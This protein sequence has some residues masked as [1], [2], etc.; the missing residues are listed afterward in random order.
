MWIKWPT[1]PG[2]ISLASMSGL[3]WG[4]VGEEMPEWN[5]QPV[6]LKCKFHSS[7]P[8]ESQAVV[9]HSTARHPSGSSTMR[10][11]CCSQRTGFLCTQI[12]CPGMLIAP[13]TE[14]GMRCNQHHGMGVRQS[15]GAY[16][17]LSQSGTTVTR[18]CLDRIFNPFQPGICFPISS[19]H[20]YGLV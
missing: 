1:T 2:D 7:Q 4:W 3:Y 17:N 20:L 15:L 16:W 11:D 10:M 8:E 6:E 12:H 5:G 9:L 13:P 14:R 19:L 18:S